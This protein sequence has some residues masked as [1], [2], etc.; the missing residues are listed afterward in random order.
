MS[1]YKHGSTNL[2]HENANLIVPSMRWLGL[3]SCDLH[4]D[5]NV[6]ESKGLLKLTV[7]DRKKAMKMLEKALLEE[8]G[9]ER[10]WRRELQVMLVLGVKA[11]ME[12]LADREGGLEGWLEGMLLADGVGNRE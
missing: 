6:E 2:S 8:S 10:E 11:E 1:T 4:T 5:K 7:R 9:G 12:L 3:R